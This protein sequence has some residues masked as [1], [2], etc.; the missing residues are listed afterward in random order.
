MLNTPNHEIELVNI[1]IITTTKVSIIG[2]KI[3]NPTFDL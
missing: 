2:I 1:E 3:S